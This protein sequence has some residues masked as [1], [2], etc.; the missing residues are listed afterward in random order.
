MVIVTAVGTLWPL[1]DF[2]ARVP[3]FFFFIFFLLYFCR[4]SCTRLLVHCIAPLSPFFSLSLSALNAVCVFVF[5]Y[6]V[7]TFVVFFFLLLL[8]ILPQPV[9][10]PVLSGAREYSL[11]HTHIYSGGH[12][13]TDILI[14]H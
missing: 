2:I 3:R 4:S 8:L 5:I 1:R 13:A 12:T 11:E 10:V 14:L 9:V 7:H 6:L